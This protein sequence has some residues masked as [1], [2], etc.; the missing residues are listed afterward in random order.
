MYY[1]CGFTPE[2]DG[3]RSGDGGAN[4]SRLRDYVAGKLHRRPRIAARGARARHGVA[5]SLP[6]WIIARWLAEKGAP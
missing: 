3:Q 2:R 5:R 1:L 6:R 4:A